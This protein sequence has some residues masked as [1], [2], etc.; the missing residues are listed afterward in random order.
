M[1]YPMLLGA[2]ALAV[3]G[4]VP[5]PA[6]AGC[7]CTCVNGQPQAI[8]SSTLDLPP[9]CPPRICPIVPPAVRPIDPPRLPPLGTSRC[10]SEQVW[11]PAS[12]RYEW[13]RL[14]D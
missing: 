8:C 3:L 7:T 1:R 6:Q 11:N 14:C 12:R 10:R 13:Q 2:A 4:F 9:L 5:E